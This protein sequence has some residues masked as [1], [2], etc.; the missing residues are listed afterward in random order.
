MIDLTDAER[1][2]ALW[3]KIERQVEARVAELRIYN[4][5]IS[6]PERDTAVLRGRISELKNLLALD[7]ATEE[8]P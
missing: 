3:R 2:S 6:L 7:S 1:N 4:D 5:A 8:A